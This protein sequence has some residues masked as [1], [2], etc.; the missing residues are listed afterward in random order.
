MADKVMKPTS[1]SRSKGVAKTPG[2]GKIESYTP[3]MQN[4]Q[5]FNRKGTKGK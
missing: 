4:I 2:G 3:S 1:P 5:A